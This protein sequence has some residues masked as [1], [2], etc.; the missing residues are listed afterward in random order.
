MLALMGMCIATQLVHLD[1]GWIDEMYLKESAIT[2]VFYLYL[3]GDMAW[4][5]Y[6]ADKAAVAEPA[7]EGPTPAPEGGEAAPA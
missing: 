1:G 5:I 3:L 2:A 7:V 4:E 6:Q